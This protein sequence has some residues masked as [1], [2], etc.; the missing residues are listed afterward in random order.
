MAYFRSGGGGIPAALKTGMN[1]VLNKKFGTTGQDYNPN[2]WPDDVNLMGA[3]E[4]KTA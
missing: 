1:N 2:D 3:L 4:I